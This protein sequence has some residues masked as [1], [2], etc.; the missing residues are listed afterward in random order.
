ME[1]KNKENEKYESSRQL[2]SF[3]AQHRHRDTSEH[4]HII[5]KM[6][7]WYTTTHL[8]LPT[9]TEKGRNSEHP[10]SR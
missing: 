2:L 4:A 6:N 5:T 3:I 7:S 1:E 9:M 8:V 10:Y